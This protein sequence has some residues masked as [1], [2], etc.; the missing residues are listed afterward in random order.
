MFTTVEH[1]AQPVLGPMLPALLETAEQVLRQAGYRDGTIMRHRRVWNAFAAFARS[2]GHDFLSNEVIEAWLASRGYPVE[3]CSVPTSP[4]LTPLLAALRI[5]VQIHAYGDVLPSRVLN[6]MFRFAHLTRPIAEPSLNPVIMQSAGERRIAALSPAFRE[7]VA[8]YERDCQAR[9][10]RPTTMKNMHL[11]LPRFF[12]FLT[13]RGVTEVTQISGAEISAYITSLH[14]YA[15]GS[16]ACYSGHARSVLRLLYQQGLLPEDLSRLVPPCG[17]KNYQNI[18]T[19]WTPEDVARLLAQ[20]DRT[21]PRGKRDYAILLLAARL[22]MRVSDIIRLTLDDLRWEHQRIELVQS[23]TREPLVL[24]LLDEIGWALIDYLKHARPATPYRQV[25][26]SLAY[27][28]APF[29]TYDN[30]HHIITKYRRMAGIQRFQHQPVG[31]HTLRHSLATQL[32]ADDTTFP[33]IA[34]VLGHTSTESTTSYA[35]VDLPHLH[36]CPLDPEEVC[37]A[38]I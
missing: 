20:V 33:V 2:H 22:G 25:F 27:P 18:P 36:R 8:R 12:Q 28:Y 3:Q 26:L 32:L 4:K 13:E 19:V 10:C 11:Y 37:D 38:I 21:S 35:K 5:L 23:K 34:E 9:G 30:L 17:I 24:P 14:N 7:A 1:N 16:V 31:M 15:P 6:P 29:V